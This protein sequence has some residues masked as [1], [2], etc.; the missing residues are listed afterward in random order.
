MLAF[1]LNTVL[2]KGAKA[3]ISEIFEKNGLTPNVKFTTWDDYAVMSM[4]ESGLGIKYITRAYFEADTV[5][6]R[7]QGA[8]CICI[9]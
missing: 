9:S 3:E 2:I 4:V 5:S 8:G 1:A 7:R 6:N